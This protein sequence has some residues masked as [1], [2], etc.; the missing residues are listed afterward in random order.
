MSA[1]GVDVLYGRLSGRL[2]RIYMKQICHWTSLDAVRL[3]C[4]FV[5]LPI[6]VLLETSGTRAV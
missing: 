3:A 2:T 1:F 4:C 5:C 6:H